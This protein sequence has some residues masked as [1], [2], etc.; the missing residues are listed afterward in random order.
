LVRAEVLVDKT[1]ARPPNSGAMRAKVLLAAASAPANSAEK[2]ERPILAICETESALS[3][4][5]PSWMGLLGRR[6]AR[7]GFSC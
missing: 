7:S 2:L 4:T 6:A 1:V 3:S 5:R